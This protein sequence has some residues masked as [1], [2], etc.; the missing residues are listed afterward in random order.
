[1]IPKAACFRITSKCN[2]NCACCNGPKNIKDLSLNEVKEV[3]K[4]LHD[5]GFKKVNIIG[6]EPLIKEDIKEIIN[7]FKKFG[8]FIRLDTSG[9]NFFKCANF[10]CNNIDILRLPIDDLQGGFRG[11]KH[12]ESLK[13]ILEFLKINKIKELRV[14]T[15]V[16][17]EN[18]ETL[19]DTKEFLEDYPINSWE[20]YEF[21]LQNNALKS[22]QKLNTSDL[23]FKKV[24]G[25]INSKKFKILI[26]KRNL[27]NR[28][29]FYIDP[30]GS[31]IMPTL[32]KSIFLDKK[33]GTI[34]DKDIVKKWNELVD[35]RNYR[36]NIE[37]MF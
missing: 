28:A 23:E 24:A 35:E 13:K 34:F 11:I 36:D 7:E 18:I 26:S 16:T 1:M 8:F 10:I 22:E 19:N 4:R 15:V 32:E 33:I 31:V 2:Y 6:G 29:Y 17:K 9:F 27:R 3:I 30:D 14:G 12:L 20:I 21:M 37:K 25:G 5:L